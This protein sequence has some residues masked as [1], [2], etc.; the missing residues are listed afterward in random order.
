M[1]DVQQQIEALR[2]QVLQ[3]SGHVAGLELIL[4]N[5]V[6]MKPLSARAQKELE[7]TIQNQALSLMETMPTAIRPDFFLGLQKS[8]ELLARWETQAR[9]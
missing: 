4:A 8:V 1:T 2:Q 3:L 5:V 6:Q 7:A 9:R